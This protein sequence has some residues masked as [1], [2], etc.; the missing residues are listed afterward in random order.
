MIRIA[1]G[2]AE[3]Q[4]VRNACFHVGPFD[5]SFDTFEDGS[6][7]GICAYSILHLVPDRQAALAK[8]YRLLKPGGFFISSTVCMGEDFIPW[9]P[10]LKVMQWLGK[11]PYVEVISKATLRQEVAAA[12]FAELSEPEVGAKPRTCFM[13]ATKPAHG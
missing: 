3:K 1:K 6:L 13:V 7:D 10:V 8:I 12:G 11:A 9:G 4:D 2:K 5:E